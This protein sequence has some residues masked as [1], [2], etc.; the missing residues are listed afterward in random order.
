MLKKV[1]SVIK[2]LFYFIYKSETPFETVGCLCPV[3]V[4]SLS[5]ILVIHWKNNSKRNTFSLPLQGLTF[6]AQSQDPVVFHLQV[7]LFLFFGL[8]FIIVAQQL[9]L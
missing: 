3:V 2:G 9:H 4:I 6:I 8:A 7:H 1:L 5:L